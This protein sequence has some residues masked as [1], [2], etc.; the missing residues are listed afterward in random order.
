MADTRPV[1]RPAGTPALSEVDKFLAKVGTLKPGPAPASE[2]GRLI[3]ALDATASREPTWDMACGL[4]AEMFDSVASTGRLDV[5]L[6][7]Y[8]GRSE[9]KASRWYFRPEQLAD[10]MSHIMCAGG[11][12]QIGRVLS[13]V[14][15]EAKSRPVSALVF[16]GDAFEESANVVVAEAGAMGVP[17]FVF[18]EGSDPEVETVFKEIANA[19]HG[20]YCRFDPGS[21]QQ[22]AELLKAVAIYAVGGKQALLK[23]NDAGSV[24]L[25]R[26]L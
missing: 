24:K 22:L 15:K 14:A 6:V 4:S 25:L 1:P 9:C 10:V 19:S 23:R 20:A 8:R 11:E 7:Y 12:T 13:H 26:Q 21:A 3:F 2:R 5:Q 17:A 16:I 18:Q